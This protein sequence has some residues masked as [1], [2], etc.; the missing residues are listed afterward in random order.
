MP[1]PDPDPSP[2]DTAP[3]QYNGFLYPHSTILL[4]SF[5]HWSGRELLPRSGDT[6]A[7]ARALFGA[8]FVVVSHGTEAEPIFN[9][10]NAL[11]LRLFELPWADFIRLPSRR[12]AEPLDQIERAQFLARVARDGYLE[13]YEGVRISATGRRF[14]I[15]EAIL[16]NLRDPAS[17][18]VWG[19]AATFARWE[20]IE[21]TDRRACCPP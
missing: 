1:H 14:R 2:A 12:S 19:Q 20:G 4:D 10:G 11:A 16:W 15:L 7:D 8:P 17:G 9:Y 21:G 6:V 3:S 13:G 5:A 18:A